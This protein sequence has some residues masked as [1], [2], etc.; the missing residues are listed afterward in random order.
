VLPLL[1]CLR[2]SLT[3]ACSTAAQIGLPPL[4]PPPR[5]PG[6]PTGSCSPLSWYGNGS[7]AGRQCNYIA[8]AC[9]TTKR[10]QA[11]RH[12]QSMGLLLEL[13]Q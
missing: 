6:S 12:R 10:T 11:G 7:F 13:V 5:P 4:P 3:L 2:A 1:L 8:T 9:T